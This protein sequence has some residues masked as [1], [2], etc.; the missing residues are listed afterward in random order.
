VVTATPPIRASP[1]SMLKPMLWWN[2]IEPP[3][4][5]AVTERTTVQPC[6]CTVLK[7]RS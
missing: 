6:A 7:K 3:F 2:L 1:G 4:T 5:G